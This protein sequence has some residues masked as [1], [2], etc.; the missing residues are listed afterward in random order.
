MKTLL[1]S[2]KART[3]G[4]R[5]GLALACVSVFTVAGCRPGGEDGTRVAGWSLIEPSERH[6]IIVSQQP[7]SIAVKV[8]RDNYGLSPHQRAQVVGFLERF[9]AAD[10]G[11]SK[12]VIQAPSGG[13]NE[14]AAMQAVA[15]M[16]QIITEM[17]FP[18]SSVA[19]EAYGAGRDGQGP[20]RLS[21][22][23]FVAEGPQCG[24]WP[25]NLAEN[26]SNL[27]YPDFGCS[28][29]RNIAAQIA[30]PADLVGPRTQQPGSSE[31]RDTVWEKYIKGDST[32]AKKAEDEKVR[33]K[34]AM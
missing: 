19:V 16:R 21:Y 34:G 13:S 3:A 2:E 26:P 9:R 32:V 10:A 31:R 27:S 30:N 33:V 12:L 20:I 1:K 11:N 18:M 25:T 22:L 24:T 17:G 14:V 7:A 8:G 28:T 6:P 5:V 29:Q 4:R 15:E 23:R